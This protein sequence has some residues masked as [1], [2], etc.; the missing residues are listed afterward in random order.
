AR[1][2]RAG[3]RGVPAR[4]RRRAPPRRPRGRDATRPARDHGERPARRGRLVRRARHGCAA[5]RR[6]GGGAP[7]RVR[8]RAG[9]GAERLMH[10]HS[11]RFG[12]VGPFPGEHSV[13]FADLAASGLF[14]LEGPTGSGKSTL[15]DM[16]VF[17]LY[18]KVAS[19]E[20]TEERLRSA[21][22]APGTE[23]YVDLVLET[24]SGIYRVRR[25]PQ[26]QRPKQRG[27]GTTTQQATV[28]LWR[29][30][31]P[32]AV[33][34]GELVST[35]LDEAGAELQRAVGLDRDQLVQTIVLP[36]GEFAGFLRA[37]PEDRR[38]LLQKVFG[39]GVYEQL[40]T[41][42]ERMRVEAQRQ[43]EDAEQRIRQAAEGFAAAARLDDEAA[44]V[45]R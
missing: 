30:T 42:L 18:G 23:T 6:R 31:S 21:H 43:V 4:A 12:A 15:I 35:R 39:T 27:T 41:R 2:V 32:D 16:I 11:L 34:H 36:Q 37:K 20:A 45:V 1:P 5:H 29:L 40:Q 28:K 9:R 22:A 25:T 19:R 10:L 44:A 33:D 13:E 17:A 24:G 14:L 3:P 7:P 38:G 26:Y 8:G